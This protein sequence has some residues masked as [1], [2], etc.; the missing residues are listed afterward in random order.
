[1]GFVKLPVRISNANTGAGIVVEGM[2]DTRYRMLVVPES[3]A[4]E[5]GVSE[6]AFLEYEGERSVTPLLISEDSSNVVI[7]LTTLTGMC[8]E[9][10]KQ[11]GEL[12]S[13]QL[14]IPSIFNHG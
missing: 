4:D 3:I 7:G 12:R 10:D 5:L 2:V 13:F 11:T 1:M 8:L 9:V 6:Y 14:M